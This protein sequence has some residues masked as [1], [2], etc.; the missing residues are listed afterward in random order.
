MTEAISSISRA[1][2]L[3]ALIAAPAWLLDGCSRRH[4]ELRMECIKRGGTWDR[5]NELDGKCLW[6]RAP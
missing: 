3:I 5:I 6:S 4:D 2:V 1:A